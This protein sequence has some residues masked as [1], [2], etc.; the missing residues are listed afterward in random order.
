[1]DSSKYDDLL[2]YLS[3]PPTSTS[4]WTTQS[5]AELLEPF[6]YIASCPGKEI[7]SQLIAAF[8]VWLQV[9]ADQL[10]VITR[11]VGL[12]HNA[13]LLVDDIEDSSE[14]RRGRPVAHKI[15][16]VPQTINTANYVYFLAYH[17]LFKMDLY[18]SVANAYGVV[19][20]PRL[21][22]RL[23]FILNEELLALHRGQGRELLW[24][25][26]LRCP[27][28]D[29]YL[30]M[31]KDKTG[32]LLRVAIRL[33]MACAT[34]NTDVLEL[35]SPRGSYWDLFQIRD[36]YM[37]LQSPAYTNNKGF[38]EDLTEGKFSFPI[39]HG[40]KQDPNDRQIIS[41]LQKRPKTP[42]LKHHV[43]SY[44]RESTHSFDYSL[45]VMQS[46]ER[47]ARAEVARLGGNTL[48]EAILDNL[49]IDCVHK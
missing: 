2:S 18:G 9:P 4:S 19:K 48:L 36:D 49:R 41:V 12:L 44:L 27:T 38:A 30:A 14:L 8:N 43:V 21:N 33:M 6:S 35:Y 45:S 17:E 5:E 40:I 3:V 47:Q 15:Y 46:L 39:V 10:D 23:T 34:T 20:R 7:R 13:S 29:E 28:E 22:H 37:N 24:R 25:D 32:G 42:T 16:G 26:S 31:V 11:V 1:M